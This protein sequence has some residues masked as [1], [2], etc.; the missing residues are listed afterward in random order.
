MRRLLL[1]AA[2]AALL[3]GCSA[4]VP[5]EEDA[6][7]PATAPAPATA[8]ETTEA[9]AAPGAELPVTRFDGLSN[10]HVEGTVAYPEVPPVGGPH[11]A[12]WLACDVY[13]EPVPP[14]TAVHSLEHGGVW[15]THRPDLPADE[16]EQLA[17][18]RALDEEYVLVSPFDGLPA[19]VVVTAWGV[20]L[21]AGSAADPGIEAFVREYAGGDQG[22]EPGAPCRTGG[23]TLDEAREAV[24]AG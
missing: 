2:A 16:V 9:E 24:G 8:P 17:A 7:G 5:A 21:Q 23:L 18:L 13:D 15:I 1:G 22:G 3:T 12:R 11:N 6:G 14:E 19:P 4:G 20:Q 10:E